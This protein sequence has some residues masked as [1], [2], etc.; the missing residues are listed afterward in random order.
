V[1]TTDVPQ[2][3]A[4][5]W[6]TAPPGAPGRKIGFPGAHEAALPAH[7]LSHRAKII[8]LV[9][10][11][12]VLTVVLVVVALLATPGPAPYCNPLKPACQGPPIDP[13][14]QF[15]GHGAAISDGVLYRNS[16]GFTV[17]Y[18]QGASVQTDAQGI[19]LTYDY[20]LGGPSYIEIL[21]GPAGSNT[22]Q[23]EVASFA[24]SEFPSSTQPAYELPDPLIGYQAAFGAAFD[25]QPASSDGSTA[26]HQVVVT[27]AVSDGF[28]IVVQVDGLLLPPVT[29]SSKFWNGHPSPAGT[30]MA[31][32]FGD[33]IDNRIGF[34]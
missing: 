2:P 14:N 32:A 11:L 16:Q 20:N 34:P 8:M 28:L 25:V 3:D 30:N 9:A 26:T 4:S 24:A 29:P 21:G 27:A 13:P 23:S 1:S 33:L 7:R 19:E 12:G 15:V 31:F 22:A 18:L 6:P 5:P 17:R 10:G